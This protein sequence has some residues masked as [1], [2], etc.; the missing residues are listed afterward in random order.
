MEGRRFAGRLHRV[1]RQAREGGE[2]T[3]TFT[4]AD[5]EVYLRGLTLFDDR[6]KE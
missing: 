4:C 5:R 1:S 3:A 6:T 2:V